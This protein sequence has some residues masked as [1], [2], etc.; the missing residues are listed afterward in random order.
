MHDVHIKEPL[1]VKKPQR[2]GHMAT[3]QAKSKTLTNRDQSG[4][5]TCLA[6]SCLALQ[7]RGKH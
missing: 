2:V 6:L 5:I 3:V 7:P 4:L 1:V